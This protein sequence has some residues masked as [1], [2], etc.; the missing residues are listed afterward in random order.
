M[1]KGVSRN[2]IYYADLHKGTGSEEH[3][4]RPVLIIQNDIGNM[5]SPTTIV[6]AITSQIALNDRLP[7]HV[8][9]GTRFGLPKDSYVMLEQIFTIDKSRLTS[10]VG[11]I[12][13]EETLGSIKQALYISLDLDEKKDLHPVSGYA[14]GERWND[15]NGK[16][17]NVYD[18]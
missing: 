2:E 11:C 8:R 10:Y 12:N 17:I 13:D 3:G 4:V 9:I 7:T 5:F 16:N 6:A 18:Q 1:P 14:K 15:K